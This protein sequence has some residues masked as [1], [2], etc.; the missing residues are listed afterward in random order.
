M[1]LL[2]IVS[3]GEYIRTLILKKINLVNIIYVLLWSNWNDFGYKLQLVEST[4]CSVLFEENLLGCLAL[5]GLKKK[6]K[7]LDNFFFIINEIISYHFCILPKLIRISSSILRWIMKQMILVTNYNTQPVW[8][9]IKLFLSPV[10][11]LIT[12]LGILRSDLY[13]YKC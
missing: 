7:I 8:L 10:F 5:I 4:L 13:R 3:G 11:L 2:V 9:G 6:R 1:V 12:T